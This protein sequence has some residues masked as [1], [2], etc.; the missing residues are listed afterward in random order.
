LYVLIKASIAEADLPE[1]TLA[2]VNELTNNVAVVIGV[3]ALGLG[4]RP[5]KG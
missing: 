3:L 2:A 4:M 5:K 1:K